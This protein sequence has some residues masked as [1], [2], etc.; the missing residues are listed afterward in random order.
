VLRI[1]GRV[2][3]LPSTGAGGLT[4]RILMGIATLINTEMILECG[5]GSFITKH[6]ED[7]KMVEE[8]GW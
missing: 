6:K 1:E 4:G 5:K 2:R 7:M 3:R 8:D